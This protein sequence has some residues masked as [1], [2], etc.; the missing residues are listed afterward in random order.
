MR[1]SGSQAFIS[2]ASGEDEIWTIPP[3]GS[4]K[5]SLAAFKAVVAAYP[6]FWRYD[7]GDAVAAAAASP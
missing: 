2:D 5:P 7:E 1:S 3:D 4:A 6:A